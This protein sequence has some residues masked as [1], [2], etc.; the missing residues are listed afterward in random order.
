M[1]T[2]GTVS[3]VQKAG[4][5]DKQAKK[6]KA[7]KMIAG[8]GSGDVR[9]GTTIASGSGTS[10]ALEAL[11]E[12]T[13]RNTRAVAARGRE[14]LNRGRGGPRGRGRDRGLRRGHN[15]CS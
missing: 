11:G 8:G 14:A 12:L 9:S 4:R 6:R 2:R 10:E 3:V 13:V 1:N 7:D 5:K 15:S